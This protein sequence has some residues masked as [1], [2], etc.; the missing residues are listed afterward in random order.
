MYLNKSN[1]VLKCDLCKIPFDDYDQPRFLPCHETICYLYV[2]KIEKE[3]SDRKFKCIFCLP[4]HYIPDSGFPI[5]KKISALITTEPVEISRS[6]EY[7]KLKENLNKLELI[8]KQIQNNYEHDSDL[9]IEH[10]NE[11]IRLIQLL[12]ENKIEQINKLNDELIA[13]VREY[14]RT[15]IES[16]IINLRINYIINFHEIFRNTISWSLFVN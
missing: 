14:E 1:D 12:T 16:Y 10:C 2:V 13:F 4:E 5:N 6:N 8:V 15:C 7:G 3:A 9:I 11:Q